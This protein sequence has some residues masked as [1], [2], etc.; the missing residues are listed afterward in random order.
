MRRGLRRKSASTATGKGNAS[1]SEGGAHDRRARR[2]RQ[3]REGSH[4]LDEA[5]RQ[6]R[7]DAGE[8]PSAARR[9]RQRVADE[10]EEQRRESSG[11]DG[12]REQEGDLA[13]HDSVNCSPRAFSD[14]DEKRTA[15]D[16]LA[17]ALLQNPNSDSQGGGGG[18]EMLR[19]SS[20]NHSRPPLLVSLCKFQVLCNRR[21]SSST[22]RS[23]APRSGD[24]A[25]ARA[26]RFSRRWRA[27]RARC[28][29]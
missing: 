23:A 7:R 3:R 17:R 18:R 28:R 4:M 8:P 29:D 15:P 21:S 5:A 14:D 24:P 22:S 6:A 1:S 12:E 19:L 25:G 20:R 26:R 16:L 9:S 13:G 27:P 2:G 11:E 10:H